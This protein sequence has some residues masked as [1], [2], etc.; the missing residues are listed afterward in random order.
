MINKFKI[1][2]SEKVIHEHKVYIET[3]LNMSQLND[4]LD[5]IED[6]LQYNSSIHDI[7]DELNTLG[8]KVS[9][10]I[11]DDLGD[12]KMEITWLDKLQ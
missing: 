8:I 1:E 7:C 5:E 10:L 2:V 4:I 11:E 6:K 12:N 9:N 3:E